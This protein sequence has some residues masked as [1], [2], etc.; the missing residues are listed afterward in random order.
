[1]SDET[2]HPD[3]YNWHPSG[4]EC[5]TIIQEFP[6]NIAAAIGY[7]WRAGHKPGVDALVDYRKA[8]QHLDFEIARI[9][10]QRGNNGG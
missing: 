7:F 8:R 5:I 9:E 6:H 4:V 10:K 3:Y 1:M 2:Q